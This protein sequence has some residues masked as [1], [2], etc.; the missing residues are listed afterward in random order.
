MTTVAVRH[1]Q[2]PPAAGTRGP[3][4]PR[5]L[6]AEWTKLVSLRST[7]WLALGTA[8]AAGLVAAGLGLFV[9]PGDGTS[10]TWVVVAGYLLSQV[11]VLVLGVLVG[12][13]EHTTGTARLTFTA[14]PRRLPVLAAQ[15]VVTAAAAVLTATVALAVAYL[16]TAG[17]RSADAPAVDLGVDGAGRALLGFVLH[18]TGVAL[19]GLGLGALLRRPAGALVTALVLLVALDQVL[20]AFSGE[21]SDVARML[22]P[23][24]AVRLLHDDAGVVL[25]EAASRAPR[26]GAWGGGAVLLG[27]VVVVLGAA[28][29]RLRHHDVR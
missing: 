26:I 16:A 19:L 23:S 14:V 2:A 15:V 25:L 28:T 7:W 18:H 11:G 12:T 6:A 21:V 5:V 27:W 17:A 29:H 10:G 22:M 24:S 4:F 1:P 13:D 9:R 3:T 8:A 20:T